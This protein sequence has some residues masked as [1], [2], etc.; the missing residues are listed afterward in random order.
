MLT[1]EL[2]SRPI[3]LCNR[4]QFQV[5]TISTSTETAIR[6]VCITFPDVRRNNLIHWKISKRVKLIPCIITVI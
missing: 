4:N 2:H 1:K 3:E 5:M 6:A